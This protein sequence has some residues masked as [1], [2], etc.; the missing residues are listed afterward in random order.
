MELIQLQ[1]ETKLVTHRTSAHTPSLSLATMRW[2]RDSGLFLSGYLMFIL[3]SFIVYTAANGLS[4]A[5]WGFGIL[6][7]G[8]FLGF[9]AFWGWDEWR[10]SRS[11]AAEELAEDH[12]V[13]AVESKEALGIMLVAAQG[14]HTSA[15]RLH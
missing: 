3:G 7:G 4:A 8:G 15:G 13:K 10:W 14:W 5:L 11:H 6:L 2:N 1:E 12:E 9:T